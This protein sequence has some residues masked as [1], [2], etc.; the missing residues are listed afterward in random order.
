M[1][2]TTCVSH[3]SGVAARL[4]DLPV[5]SATVASVSGRLP[6]PDESR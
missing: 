6:R 1:S 4:A 2:T 3:V 5:R